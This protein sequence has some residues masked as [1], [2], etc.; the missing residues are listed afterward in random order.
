MNY[1]AFLLQNPW[2]SGKFEDDRSIPREILP[3]VIRDLEEREVTVITGSRQ[4]GKTTLLMDMIAIL[5]KQGVPADAIFYFNLDDFNLF[6]YFEVYTDFLQFIDSEHTGFTYVFIDEI[7]RLENPGLFLKILYD[8]KLKMKLVVSGSSSLELRAKISEHLTGRKHTFEM[9]PFNF[10][11]FLAARKISFYRKKEI[12]ALV[13]FHGSDMDALLKEFVTYG[14]YPKAIL[15]KGT[16]EKAVELKEIYDS[17]VKKDVKDFLKIENIAGY[18]N[19]VKSLAL[20][21]G[22]LVNYN[23]LRL[24]TGL[25]VQTVKKYIDYLEGTYIF[26]KVPPYFTNARKEIAKAPKVYAYDMGLLNYITGRLNGSSH[27]PGSLME[28]FVFSELVK[29]GLEVKFWR[30]SSGAEVDFVINGVPIE[31]KSAIMKE[32]S[33]SKSFHSYLKTYEPGIGFWV[34]AN[35]YGER[36]VNGGKVVFY[37]L[38]AVPAMVKRLSTPGTEREKEK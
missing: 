25:N 33:L 19:L 23:R 17:Y 30:S 36:Q 35:Y 37:P 18:N 29:G 32:P 21:A 5:L 4:V 31:V 9:Y 10:E 26:K 3:L 1:S 27:D 8:L 13:K 12:E 2:R 7:Q 38:W 14:G 16:R 11:E 6:P 28:N 24:L 15:G 22:N 34:S 20:Q